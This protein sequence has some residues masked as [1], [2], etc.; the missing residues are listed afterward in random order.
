MEERPMHLS[1]WTALDFLFAL[2]ILVSTI[3]ALTKGL[4]REIISL[5]VLIGGFALAALFIPS[6]PLVWPNSAGRNPSQICWVS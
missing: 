5:V 6:L 1:Q 3:F 4:V 2:I